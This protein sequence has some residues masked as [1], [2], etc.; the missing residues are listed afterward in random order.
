M[1]VSGVQLSSGLPTQGS[2][3]LCLSLHVTDVAMTLAAFLFSSLNWMDNSFICY[4]WDTKLLCV[5]SFSLFF[6]PS[7]PC[8]PFSY[9]ALVLWSSSSC[10]HRAVWKIFRVLCP[11]LHLAAPPRRSP[12]GEG[13]ASIPGPLC[14]WRSAFNLSMSSLCTFPEAMWSSRQAMTCLNS[15]CSHDL[16]PCPRTFA[17]CFSCFFLLCSYFSDHL[18]ELNTLKP[19]S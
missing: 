11:T 6:P 4:F 1:L 10:S 14:F 2:L 19:W 7:A 15:W 12:G 3:S 13:V 17:S 9:G 8:F 18:S 16:D 5:L